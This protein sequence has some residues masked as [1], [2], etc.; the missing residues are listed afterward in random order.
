MGKVIKRLGER[1]RKPPI[2]TQR[3]SGVP[4]PEHLDWLIWRLVVSE[5]ATLKEIETYYDL[6]DVLDAHLALDIKEEAEA[7]ALESIDTPGSR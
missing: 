4:I 1:N 2:K 7:R 5:I 3:D 6:A